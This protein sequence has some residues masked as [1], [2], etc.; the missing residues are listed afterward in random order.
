LGPAT[1]RFG[2]KLGG[3]IAYDLDA[4]GNISNGRIFYR[5]DNLVTDGMAMDTD[6][7]LY[8][9]AHNG[10]REPPAGV[11]VVIDP[12]GKPLTKIAPPEGFRPGNIG[13][14]RG[15]DAHTLYATTLFKWRLFRIDTNRRGHYWE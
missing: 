13:F 4:A 11:I 9:A 3:V 2:L 6:G 5:N 15:V 14:G 1:D 7:N 10:A 12:S 8:V